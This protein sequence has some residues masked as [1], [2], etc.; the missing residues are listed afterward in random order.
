MYKEGLSTELL[1]AFFA[2]P[3]FIKKYESYILPNLFESINDLTL[4]EALL[5]YT[6]EFGT[7]ITFTT[8]ETLLNGSN[9]SEVFDRF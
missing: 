9:S 8:L 2:N 6:V 1:K 7:P 3:G 4:Y 5:K